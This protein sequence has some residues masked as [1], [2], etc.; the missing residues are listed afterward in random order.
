C[1]LPI[2]CLMATSTAKGPIQL[3]S[4]CTRMFGCCPRHHARTLVPERGD[5]T[6]KIGLFIVSC[7]S[8]ANPYRHECEERELRFPLIQFILHDSSN[9]HPNRGGIVDGKA[10]I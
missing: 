10:V 6:T 3:D 2:S 7:I 4:G 9:F 5:P 1:A 8:V